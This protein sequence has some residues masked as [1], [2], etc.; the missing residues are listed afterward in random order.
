VAGGTL[1]LA[2]G[3]SLNAATTLDVSGGGDF[4]LGGNT[5]S[6]A[7]L[8]GAGGVDLRDGALSVDQTTN[9]A[10]NGVMRGTGSLTKAGAGTLTLTDANTYSGATQ[11]AGGTLA[12]ASGASLNAATTLDISL[13]ATFRLTDNDQTVTRLSGAGT[14][15]L[16]MGNLTL[17]LAPLA[18]DIFPGTVTGAG[19]LTKAGD[20]RLTV[21]G[22]GDHVGG[23][24]V[25]AGTLRANGDYRSPVR[26]SPGARLE[27]IGSVGNTTVSGTLAPGNS[28]GVIAVNGDLAFDP[29]SIYEVEIDPS[30]AGDRTDVNGTAELD[31]GTV[32]V[33]AVPG[34]YSTDLVY[35]ILTATEPITSTFD[36][37]TVDLAFLDPILVHE[38]NQVL[39]TFARNSEPIGDGGGGVGDVL[40]E[41]SPPPGSDGE[42]VQMEV[43]GLSDDEVPGA[44]QSL[45]GATLGPMVN[46][47]RFPD[48][49]AD[50]LSGVGFAA[51]APASMAEASPAEAV[52]LA[53]AGDDLG[54]LAAGLSQAGP[55]RLRAGREEDFGLWAAGY[56]SFGEQDGDRR[57]PAYD[58]WISGIA[59]GFDHALGADTTWGLAV[60]YAEGGISHDNGDDQELEG[61]R[62]ALYGAH[63]LPLAGGELAIEA[64]AGGA[65]T[66]F[67]SERVLRFGALDRKA[68]GETEA[69]SYWGNLSLRHTSELARGVELSPQASL[70]ALYTEVDGFTETGAGA[71]NLIVSDFDATSLRGRFG[72]RLSAGIEAGGGWRIVPEARAF[73]SHEFA[74]DDVTLDLRMAGLGG[75]F[76]TRTS[77]TARTSGVF[78]LN[79]SARTDGGIAL[80]LDYE[81]EASRDRTVHSVF[82]G[83]QIFW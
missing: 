3:A 64:S 46:T 49:V 42:T 37:L 79:V 75:A 60:G 55:L 72:A 69:W 32:A 43:I 1:A 51:S 68:K 35:Q 40:D 11:V 41:A 83:I 21:T 77:K 8:T 18:D 74:D 53:F 48:V 67:D 36:G 44:L 10:F 26:V 28:I 34:S 58:N 66:D 54:D 23:T 29:G 27:G 20:G 76:T 7:G 14:L 4:D 61:V 50:H 52:Q 19:I 80:F 63:R 78:G 38:T 6:V 17:D 22:T 82:G 30:G 59:L 16:G 9:G 33:L 25:L 31:G 15:D 2:S 81:G 70:R 45:G 5:Q 62:A 13:P 39:L 24:D 56:A 57:A 71:A 73:V 65:Y 12:L 47:L